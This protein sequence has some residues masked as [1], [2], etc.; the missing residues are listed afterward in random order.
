MLGYV[1]RRCHPCI[2]RPA[3]GKA[4]NMER[5]KSEK[6]VSSCWASKAR[7]LEFCVVVLLTSC[8]RRRF[9]SQTRLAGTRTQ[10]SF[11]QVQRECPLPLTSGKPC[12]SM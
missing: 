5:L 3:L 1:H 4:A 2:N 7:W 9:T 12:S 8:K 10:V 6:L 11:I